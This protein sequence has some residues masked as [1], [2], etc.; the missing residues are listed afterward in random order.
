MNKY[1]ALA[2]ALAVILAAYLTIASPLRI[3]SSAHSAQERVSKKTAVR[4]ESPP[5]DDQEQKFAG[6]PEQVR[7]NYSTILTHVQKRTAD[8]ISR[9]RLGSPSLENAIKQHGLR[10]IVS[11]GNKAHGLCLDLALERIRQ[12]MPEKEFAERTNQISKQYYGNMQK[13][14]VSAPIDFTREIVISAVHRKVVLDVLFYKNLLD[15]DLKTD[16]SPDY[17]ELVQSSFS[18]EQYSEQVLKQLSAIDN[19][20]DAL[21]KS[22]V[23]FRGLFAVSGINK[24]R[25]F[26]K[27]YYRE[28]AEKTYR[29][30][31]SGK[32]V[33]K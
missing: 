19:I 7:A 9:A 28:Q 8:Y 3:A 17:T 20:Y 18:P 30:R 13:V 22:R 32:V 10:K 24:S 4:V 12:G 33:Q 27:E 21:L 23:G 6:L 26:R 31:H 15:S 1:K 11:V 5:G 14:N 2:V 25:D 16:Q 29:S